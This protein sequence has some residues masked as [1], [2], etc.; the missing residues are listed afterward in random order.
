MTSIKL[1]RKILSKQSIMMGKMARFLIRYGEIALKTNWVRRKFQN[2]LITNIQDHFLDRGVECMMRSEYG[3]IYLDT[4]DLDQ[5]S[6]ILG[7]IFGITSF[8]VVETT[9][10]EMEDIAQLAIER[11]RSDL[12]PGKKFAVRA[13]RTGNHEYT[14]QELANFVGGAIQSHLENLV[15]D[16]G[17]PDIEVFIEVRGK[18]TY[19]FSGRNPGPGGMPLG[20]QGT[21]LAVVNSPEGLVGAWLMMKRGCKVHV[22]H[23]G[24]SETVESLRNWDVNLKAHS[25]R[26]WSDLES[27]V[28]RTHPQG[29]AVTWVERANVTTARR[30]PIFYPTIGLSRKELDTMLKRIWT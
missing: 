26:N 4:G 25:L 1:P 5:A 22:S 23:F 30:L 16:L 12:K 18:T 7:R 8:S 13:R 28:E 15:V 10:S 17:R 11:F 19:V 20:T 6:E 24:E 29:L 2:K 14:S 21:V 3:R 27:L 9:S